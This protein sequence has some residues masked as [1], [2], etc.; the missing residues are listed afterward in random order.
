MNKELISCKKCNNPLTKRLD[1]RIFEFKNV[2]SIK[3]IASHNG[4]ELKIECKKCNDEI[5]FL[6]N[7]I[8]LGL[9]YAVVPK[10]KPLI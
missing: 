8:P 10:N 9:S 4:N 1:S 3:S 2:K 7:E 6:V 5:K